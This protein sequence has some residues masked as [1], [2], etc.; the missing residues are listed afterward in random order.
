MEAY[1]SFAEVYD[2]FMDN[3]PYEEWAAYIIGLLR[4]YH[5]ESGIVAE[6]GCGTGSMTRLLSGA[7]YD[8]IG[9]DSSMEMLD[10]AR[11]K[12]QGEDEAQKTQG[13]LY[14]MQDMRE[15]ELY[16]TVAA[17]VSVCDCVN[18]ITEP[19]ALL[20]V[21]RLVNN[22][23]DPEGIFIFDFHPESYYR[24][25]LADETFAEDREEMSFIWD[26]AYDPAT[27]LNIYD[28]SVFVRGADGRYGKFQE[29]HYQRGYTIEE[30]R[31]LI[32][33]SG[34]RLLA[35][36]DA[37]THKPVQA[38]SERVHV[39]AMEQGKTGE[40]KTNARNENE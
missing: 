31:R 10:M 9:I 27:Q 28:I 36:Y 22:Y 11:E 5:I 24:E 26:N 17:I 29:T 19:D 3:V 23:L 25:Q 35:V 39:I 16:G 12:T 37:F 18:Y 1:T 21:F 20:E 38:D 7:G 30:M 8:M 40:T 14:L 6:L 34:L 2:A 32:E 4:E 33:Q 13:I 15:F